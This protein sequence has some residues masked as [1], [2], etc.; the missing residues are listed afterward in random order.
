VVEKELKLKG[1]IARICMG[2]QRANRN[3]EVQTEALLQI[4]NGHMGVGTECKTQ[5]PNI[6]QDSINNSGGTNS[7]GS[8]DFQDR[9]LSDMMGGSS[10]IHEHQATSS[11]QTAAAAESGLYAQENT[12]QNY[13]S[14]SVYEATGG[15][16]PR[17]EL[18]KTKADPPPVK[19]SKFSNDGA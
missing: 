11:H 8:R 9:S 2:G 14:M 6:T 19:P 1:I 3:Q 7:I 5:T 18:G 15:G 10:Q 12:L 17:N 4:K 13:Q 16:Y